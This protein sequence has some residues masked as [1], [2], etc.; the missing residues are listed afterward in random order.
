MILPVLYSRG[1]SGF[2]YMNLRGFLIVVKDI[3]KSQQ[4]YHDLFGLDL[5]QD[6][7][8]NMILE[9]GLV[10]QEEQ[11]WKTFIGKE[12]IMKNNA[13][14]LYFEEAD[15]EAFVKKLNDLYP[16]TEYVNQLMTHTW[17][18]RVVR[19]YDLDGTLIEV[20]TPFTS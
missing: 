17:G 20:G 11:Y 2:E 3:R 7:D 16:D 8:G 10:L 6:N 5:I 12:I 14:E 4:Y 18:Q 19:F 9:G 1:I 15:I 13:G